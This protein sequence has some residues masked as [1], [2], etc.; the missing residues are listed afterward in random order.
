MSVR[1]DPSP[2]WD[3]LI[4]QPGSG[5]PVWNFTKYLLDGEGRLVGRWSSKV[6]PEDPQIL[7]AVESALSQPDRD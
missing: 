2:L 7:E 6:S 4:R 1:A 5:P 3:D